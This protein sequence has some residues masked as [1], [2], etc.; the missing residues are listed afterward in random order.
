M[1]NF[2]PDESESSVV[3]YSE[4][5]GS[6]GQG[7]GGPSAPHG[8]HP[9][10]PGAGPDPTMDPT[11][12]LQM[13]GVLDNHCNI[14][15]ELTELFDTLDSEHQLG[16][17]LSGQQPSDVPVPRPA[18]VSVGVQTSAPVKPCRDQGRTLL[19]QLQQNIPHL[20]NQEK[21][22]QA[23]LLKEG[24]CFIKNQKR[25]NASQK[26]NV[27]LLKRQVR[28]LHAEIA[29][30][31]DICICIYKSAAIKYVCYWS[32]TKPNEYIFS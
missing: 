21:L 32:I 29:G 4:A 5:A 11:H 18:M 9:S 22:S 1:L 26:E 10:P 28:E 25:E 15:D 3:S 14:C 6:S 13:Y 17:L 19:E 7:Q 8:H 16:Y 31:F 12:L 23:R 27:E 30:K 2:N 20:K 24:S